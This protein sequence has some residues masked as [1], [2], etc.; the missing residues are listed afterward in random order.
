MLS[1]TDLMTPLT[2]EQV[3]EQFLT[4]LEA[5]NIPARSWRTG[6]AFRNILKIV[7]SCYAGFTTVMVAFAKSGFLDKSEGGWLTLLAFHVYGVTRRPAT[8]ATG[9]VLFTNVGGGIH[10]NVAGT[11]RMR[12][13]SKSYVTTEDLALVNPGDTQLVAVRAVEV[14]SASSVIA[15]QITSLETQLLGV[16]ITNPESVV[17]SDEQD[18]ENLRETCR[19]KL[20]ALS[21]LGPR[22][23]YAYAVDVALRNDGSPV[24]INR[25]EIFSDD[26]TGEVTVYVAS[27]S[28]TPVPDDLDRVAE[29]VERWARPDSVTAH[30]LGATPVA[31]SKTLTVWAS[32]TPGLDAGTVQTAVE[33]ALVA[34]VAAYPIGGKKKPPATQGYLF[35]TN[36]EGAAKG[37]HSAIFAV[38]GVG[39][40]L[41]INVGEVATLSAVVTV[42]LV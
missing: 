12:A 8:F 3:L 23:A 33:D 24:D 37:A 25:H 5:L 42:R 9:F 14:G 10:G 34:L 13:G 4:S 15:G 40:D 18:D 36:I 39:S 35:A 19:N 41:A 6:G 29:S 32:I 17:G 31:F 1:V 7:A 38:D 16:T 28:G 22:G 30:V 27:P 26:T 11:V 20:A 21:M 2:E